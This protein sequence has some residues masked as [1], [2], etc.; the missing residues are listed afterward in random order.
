[1]K[2]LDAS[3]SNLMKTSAEHENKQTNGHTR[4]NRKLPGGFNHVRAPQGAEKK[5]GNKWRA[6]EENSCT[7]GNDHD[8]DNKQLTT[9]E[10]QWQRAQIR[11]LVKFG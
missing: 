1:M 11:Y 3:G 9:S 5:E 2:H 4:T 6:R 8:D 10:Q 7:S